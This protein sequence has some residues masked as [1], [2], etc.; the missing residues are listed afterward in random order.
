MSICPSVYVFVCVCVCVYLCVCLSVCLCVCLCVCVCVFSGDRLKK[1][2]SYFLS[3]CFQKGSAD[4]RLQES[5]RNNLHC[6][7]TPCESSRNTKHTPEPSTRNSELSLLG[8]GIVWVFFD[9]GAK[10]ILLKRY[11]CLNGA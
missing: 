8:L 5:I 6:Y 4:Q 7:S 9:T 10:S 1:D 11:R 2:L 3:Q